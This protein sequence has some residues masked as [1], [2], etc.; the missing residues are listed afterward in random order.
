MRLFSCTDCRRRLR[1]FPTSTELL[2]SLHTETCGSDCPSQESLRLL[3]HNSTG[4]I[5]CTNDLERLI[6]NTVRLV[7]GLSPCDLLQ[8]SQAVQSL[9]SL[10]RRLERILA[11]LGSTLD[12]L[13]WRT[14]TLLSSMSEPES[15]PS[16]PS[17][18]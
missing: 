17:G 8:S 13:G 7:D 12:E 9:C 10:E 18:D 11:S 2:K 6:E 3:A 1:H 15:T 5:L 16:S 4:S 14:T